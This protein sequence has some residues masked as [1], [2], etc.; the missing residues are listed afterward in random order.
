[1]VNKNGSVS[2]EVTHYNLE[3]L[4]ALGYRIRSKVATKF[5]QWATKHLKE[6]MTKG[7][8]ETHPQP[9]MALPTTYLEALKALVA[10]EE[11]KLALQAERDEAVRTK[12]HFVEG[13]DAKICGELGGLRKQNEEL[14]KQVGDSKTYKA[15]T[16]IQWLREYFDTSNRGLPLALSAA[17]KKIEAEMPAKYAHIDIPDSRWGT[18]KAYHV[19]VV[20]RLHEAVKADGKFMCKYRKSTHETPPNRE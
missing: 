11:A 20:E 6:L 7:R 9:K 19:A 17:L 13:R 12:Y 1:M 18:V 10:S 2:R 5:R 3:M 15:V 8:T 4:I 16:A 14:R